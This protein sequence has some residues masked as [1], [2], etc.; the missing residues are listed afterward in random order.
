MGRFS[1]RITSVVPVPEDH[2]LC[3][4]HQIASVTIARLSYKQEETLEHERFETARARFGD[5]WLR[6]S[7]EELQKRKSEDEKDAP[8]PDELD[9]VEVAIVTNGPLHS[10]LRKCVVAFNGEPATQTDLMQMG[11]AI[12]KDE[13]HWIAEKV[14]RFSGKLPEADSGN[15]AGSDSTPT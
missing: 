3:T 1:K 5:E 14:L 8:E 10:L 15:G 13:A 9:P 11:D 6:K 2:S 4:G 12:S 7:G